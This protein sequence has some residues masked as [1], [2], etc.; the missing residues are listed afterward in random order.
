MEP[1]LTPFVCVCAPSYFMATDQLAL[2]WS[3]LWLLDGGF[4]LLLY[5]VIF[6]C[7]AWLWRPSSDS[8]RYAYAELSMPGSGGE[9]QIGGLDDEDEFASGE[10]ELSA[11]DTHV[12]SNGNGNGSSTQQ[13]QHHTPITQDNAKFTVEEDEDEEA[14]RALEQKA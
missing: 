2:H 13:Q 8:R 3:L 9:M 10:V 11:H 12:A 5:T 14:A 1:L 4:Q 7:M 6:L